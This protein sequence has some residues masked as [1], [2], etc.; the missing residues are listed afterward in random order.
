MEASVRISGSSIQGVQ[1]NEQASRANS[2]GVQCDEIGIS[3]PRVPGEIQDAPD[4]EQLDKSAKEAAD[5]AKSCGVDLA[6]RNFIV[7][8]LGFVGAAVGLGAAIAVTVLTGGAGAPLLAFAGVGFAMALA[9]ACCALHD[10]RSKAGGGSGLPMEGDSIGNAVY[11]IAKRCKTSDDTAMKVGTYTSLGIRSAHLL[12]GLLTAY[13]DPA[14]TAG[15]AKQ[16]VAVLGT[17]VTPTLGEIGKH[18]AAGSALRAAEK[19]K[20]EKAEAQAQGQITAATPLLQQNQ[21]LSAQKTEAE[22]AL[23]EHKT[24]ADQALNAML[25]EQGAD[26]QQI[27]ILQFYVKQLED[28][29]AE[30]SAALARHAVA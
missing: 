19:G 15:T 22:Q 18:V 26:N 10:W 6:K 14:T 4:L 27:G 11:A 2:V 25:R 24:Q 7:K 1:P 16:V 17:L 30:Q 21:A 8:A 13:L 3:P 29:L 9:D 20:Q 12:G 5:K 23:A 28:K